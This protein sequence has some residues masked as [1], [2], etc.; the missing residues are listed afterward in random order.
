RCVIEGTELNLQ[1]SFTLLL[2]STTQKSVKIGLET[3][4]SEDCTSQMEDMIPCP[5]LNQPITPFIKCLTIVPP[6]TETLLEA[7]L[8]GRSF[9]LSQEFLRIMKVCIQRLP[10]FMFNKTAPTTINLV[11]AVA[12]VGDDIRNRTPESVEDQHEDIRN[13]FSIWNIEY[14]AMSI[15]ENDEFII[16]Q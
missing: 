10:D 12:N 6:S 15:E 4:I 9:N 14:E 5:L 7:L 16:M 2:T 11:E 1:D 8:L 13:L 3:L